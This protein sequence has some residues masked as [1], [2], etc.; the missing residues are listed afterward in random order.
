MMTPR[1]KI[2]FVS[3]EL[4]YEA[5]RL[6]LIKTDIKLTGAATVVLKHIKIYKMFTL[7][8]K[9]IGR[10]KTGL[11]S[12]GVFQNHYYTKIHQILTFTHVLRLDRGFETIAL[13][14]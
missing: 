9:S 10:K 11:E 3:S 6:S 14:G 7:V 5:N 4:E 1:R 13:I 2:N 8:C 12:P